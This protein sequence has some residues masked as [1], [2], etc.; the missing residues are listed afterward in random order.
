MELLLVKHSVPAIDRNAPPRSWPLSEEGRVR[1]RRLAEL[2]SERGVAR[3][4]ASTEPKAIETASIVAE[5]LGLDLEIRDGLHEH[6]LIGEWFEEKAAFDAAVVRFFERSDELVLGTE[7]ARA[8]GERFSRAMEEILK[9]PTTG[10]LVVVTHG[11]V[12]SLYAAPL[13]GED[14]SI[15]WRRLGL[16]ALVA[17]RLPGLEP[18]SVVECL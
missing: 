1:A 8:A 15:F 13:F 11:R 14:V 9:E 12:M 3:V 6:E 10:S 2:L 5:P 16:P 4:V 7:T 17:L 18:L